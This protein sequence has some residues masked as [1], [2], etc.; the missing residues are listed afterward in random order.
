MTGSLDNKELDLLKK[1][2][3]VCDSPREGERIAAL[4]RVIS[5]LSS[6][7]L[8]MMDLPAVFGGGGDQV[9][10]DA[11][12]AAV[13]LYEDLY[14]N[15]QL[16]VIKARTAVVT[17]NVYAARLLGDLTNERERRVKL[18][19]EITALRAASTPIHVPP[20]S[21]PWSL[22]AR[23][24]RRATTGPRLY[25]DAMMVFPQRVIDQHREKLTAQ[26]AKAWCAPTPKKRRNSS[27]RH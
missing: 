17:A 27:V 1:L 6:H 10:L 7:G 22:P 13:K 9:K 5:K 25:D 3:A 21:I 23:S 4:G 18:E 2:I 15:E 11:L 12:R 14:T 8:R 19:A 16:E 20:E 24:R 26:Q